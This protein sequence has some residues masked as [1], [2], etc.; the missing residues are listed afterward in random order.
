MRKIDVPPHE[1]HHTAKVR[2]Y[3]DGEEK[4]W[5][6]DNQ[7]W[8]F[9]PAFAHAFSIFD[10]DSFYDENYFKVDHVGPDTV[11]KYV[12]HVLAF[13]AQLLGRPVE[14]VFE[15][16][17][18]GGWFTEELI[19]RKIDVMAVEGTRVGYDRSVA[20]GV[21]R[22]QIV[23]HDL[24]VPLSLGRQFDMALCTEVAEHIECPFSSQLV[25]NLVTHSQ[26]VW[27]SFEEPGTND[28]H[29]HHSNEQPE[30]FWINLF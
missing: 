19:R 10:L 8:W 29:Y 26:L 1:T 6:G 5:L 22:S 21:P 7:R 12:D 17:S 13:G 30:P 3:V 27:F 28:A 16:G 15:A 11:T 2:A 14:S 24:R 4:G 9:D 18:A 25:Q 23:H 20:R